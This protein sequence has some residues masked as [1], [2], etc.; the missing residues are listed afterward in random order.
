MKKAV[1]M[2]SERLFI[3]CDG[4][5]LV[6]LCLYFRSWHA[7]NPQILKGWQHVFVS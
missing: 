6:F 3:R 1:P 7:A 4:E 5:F 2:R